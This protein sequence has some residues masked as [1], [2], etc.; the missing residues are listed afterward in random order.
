MS[1]LID[2]HIKKW[3]KS[4]LNSLGEYHSKVEVSF[5]NERIEIPIFDGNIEA[6][7]GDIDLLKNQMMPLLKSKTYQKY[8]VQAKSLIDAIQKV[9]SDF[10][11]VLP[12]NID[13]RLSHVIDEFSRNP[14]HFYNYTMYLRKWTE[15]ELCNF[16]LAD[17]CD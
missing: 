9:E 2:N 16:K 10:Y 17:L 11:E 3:P 8:N 14:E 5:S 7:W 1:Q 6:S 4:V 15:Q 12:S 13:I